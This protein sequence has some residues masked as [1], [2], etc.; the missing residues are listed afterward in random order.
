MLFVSNTFD[1]I[2][3][4]DDGRKWVGEFEDAQLLTSDSAGHTTIDAQNLCAFAKINAFFQN[5]TLPGQENFCPTEAGPFGVT[6]A[7]G[8][9]KRSEVSEITKMI[10]SLRSKLS[11]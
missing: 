11:L 6:L 2:T 5:G 3:P 4:I 9:A 1:P 8:L 10:K 7:G